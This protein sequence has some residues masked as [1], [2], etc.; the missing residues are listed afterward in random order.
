MTKRRV[1]FAGLGLAAAGMALG[2]WTLADA[3]T[4][5]PL[6]APPQPSA[7]SSPA[8][9]K[10]VVASA[11]TP[12]TRGRVTVETVTL[13][14][15]AA[16][17]CLVSGFPAVTFAGSATASRL[18]TGRLSNPSSALLDPQ[19]QATFALRYVRAP[20]ASAA[21]CALVIVVGGTPAGGA[22]LRIAP[23]Q[24]LSEVD[25]SSFT[26][27][28]Q[29]A[30]PTP[31]PLTPPRTS[32]V[33]RPCGSADLAVRDA[34]SEPGAGTQRAVIAVQNRSLTSCLVPRAMRAQLLGTQGRLMALTVVASARGTAG[35]LALRAGHE[36]SLTLAFTTADPHGNACPQSRAVALV[37]PN[38]TFTASAP[39]ELAPCPGPD[40]IAIRETPLR[41][42]VPLPGFE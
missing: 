4:F 6:V 2:A 42:G 5:P 38:G 8:C 17:P 7:S 28:A 24:A 30:T 41:P 25:V 9:G 32:N 19:N 14:V 39:A 12:R 31:V 27:L 15:Q 26:S 20:G 10:G 13:T 16:T 37:F 11:G 35:D 33:T 23:C 36:A 29:G 1:A 34:G 18:R 40:G 3:Q 22:P 21:G